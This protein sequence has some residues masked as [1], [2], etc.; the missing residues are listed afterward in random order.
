MATK[1][2][3]AKAIAAIHR[4]EGA[5]QMKHTLENVAHNVY[6]LSQIMLDSYP[7]AQTALLE[8]NHK[9]NEA[10]LMM[11]YLKIPLYKYCILYLKYGHPDR[12]PMKPNKVDLERLYKL[13]G[14]VENIHQFF[15]RRQP[16]LKKRSYV[17]TIRKY[18]LFQVLIHNLWVEDE[19]TCLQDWSQNVI[20]RFK[21]ILVEEAASFPPNFFYVDHVL[22]SFLNNPGKVFAFYRAHFKETLFLCQAAYLHCSDRTGYSLLRSLIPTDH[23]EEPHMV[24]YA[25]QNLAMLKSIYPKKFVDETL[26][27]RF[28]QPDLDRWLNENQPKYFESIVINH[29]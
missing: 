21:R 24:E 5:D 11:E 28:F 10:G 26:I 15:N 25:N 22:E 13:F 1:Q 17:R 3:I 2:R 18:G 6:Q 4:L 7:L 20:Y 23:K 29:T 27:K 12:R 8:F 16:L 9:A 19:D 14:S